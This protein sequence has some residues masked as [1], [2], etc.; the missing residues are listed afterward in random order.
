MRTLLT[1]LIILFWI[2]ALT[3]L[4]LIQY[5]FK[6]PTTR[7][8]PKALRHTWFAGVGRTVAIILFCAPIF[9]AGNW[10]VALAVLT[11]LIVKFRNKSLR[12][13]VDDLRNHRRDNRGIFQHSEDCYMVGGKTATFM[14][15]Y[16]EYKGINPF[17]DH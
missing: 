4:L 11:I 8:I 10:V 1:Y 16:F 13:I 5:V 9:L 6:N 7:L 2:A 12:L 15:K 14:K 3:I 17:E